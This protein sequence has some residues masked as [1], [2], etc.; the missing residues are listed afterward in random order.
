LA[1]GP[2][3]RISSG[4]GTVSPLDK[5]GLATL[6]S[7][8]TNR[9]T[10]LGRDGILEVIRITSDMTVTVHESLTVAPTPNM[11]TY[12][13]TFFVAGFGMGAW[14]PLVP[15]ARARAGIEEGQLGVLLLCL[16]L[17][18]MVMM[19]FAG[20]LTARYGCRFTMLLACS[21][22]CLCLPM[23]ATVSSF[24][25]LIMFLV[26]FGAGIGIADVTMNIQ[27]V[28]VEQELGRS[29]M[30]GFHGLFS[31]GGIISA[32]GISALLWL[33]ASPLIATLGIVAVIVAIMT[34]HGRRML[35]Y[36]ADDGGPLF[37]KPSGKIL[38]LGMLCFISFLVEGS[39]L[40]WSAVFLASVRQVHPAQAGLGYA[41]FA[42]MMAL[43]RLNGDRIKEQMGSRTILIG[44]CL[45]AIGGFLMAVMLTSWQWNLLGFALVGIGISN[46]VPVFCSLAG[47]QTQMPAGLAI[48][49]LTSIGY[50][51]ILLGPA[52]IGFM[53]QATN[54]SCAFLAVA[55][56]L[57]VIM[58]SARYI[59]R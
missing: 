1:T 49:A 16:G 34:L 56:L 18:S 42:V 33:G 29:L 5:P 53:A 4:L 20:L 19:P 41:V 6:I 44:G 12:R 22:V 17:G 50:V 15:F 30:S 36:G 28:I 37:V 23:L 48:S 35:P 39:M 2:D 11:L 10:A 24:S 26:L 8:K 45:I 7:V 38:F 59:V 25:G 52:L 58:L 9:M 40:D 55:A 21:V 14:A 47:T 57:S 43:G 27:G 31:L 3:E 54:L 46:T 51:G 13:L 32:G